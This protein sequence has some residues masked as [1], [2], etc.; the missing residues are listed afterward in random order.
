MFRGSKEG[1]GVLKK[2]AE[3][4]RNSTA[5]A[6]HA[7]FGGCLHEMGQ[8][9]FGPDIWFVMLAST[10]KEVHKFLE[11]LLESYMQG[12]DDYLDAVGN[13]IDIIGFSDD[14]G[15]QTGPQISKKMY[16]E[17]YKP[18]HARMWK[19]VKERTDAKIM[20]HCCGGV[21]PL[22]P[23]F[24]E[25]GLDI[26]NP[27]QVNCVG[28]NSGDLKRE[29]GKDL[30]FWGGGCDTQRVLPHGTTEDVEEEVKR[31]IN[32][33]APG[34]GFVFSAVHNIQANVP[35]KNIAKMFETVKKFGKYQKI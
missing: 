23:S 22:I 26:I 7:W 13:C 33:L 6:I 24:I 31:R 15:M 9:L 30:V 34:G 3:K 5:K 1:L 12:L 27:V 8:F 35:V 11:K 28:M 2:G 14:L 32:D 20:L 10:K 25:A 4:L 17:F 29:F 19:R 18:R 16:E 21:Y